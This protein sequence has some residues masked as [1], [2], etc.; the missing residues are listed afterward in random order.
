MNITVSEA[1]VKINQTDWDLVTC[2]LLISMGLSAIHVRRDLIGDEPLPP[3]TTDNWIAVFNDLV[4]ALSPTMLGE[5]LM[6]IP[7]TKNNAPEGPV[8]KSLAL[9]VAE[10]IGSDWAQAWYRFVVLVTKLA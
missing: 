8:N 7:V 4:S 5:L 2:D 1:V 6:Q 9:T 3:D 10:T